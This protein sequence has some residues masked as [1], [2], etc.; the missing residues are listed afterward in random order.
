MSQAERRHFRGEEKV[1]IL[2]LHLLEGKAV[3]DLCEQHKI[4]PSLFYQW[5]RTFFENGMRAFEGSSH[6]LAG[7]FEGHRDGDADSL[8]AVQ[9]PAL[10][11]A[12]VDRDERY[13]DEYEGDGDHPS[14][15]GTTRSW[16]GAFRPSDVGVQDGKPC[17]SL[18]RHGSQQSRA[19]CGARGRLPSGGGRC[20]CGPSLRGG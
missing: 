9:G 4:T 18:P 5:Q 10:R 8:R 12:E 11:L 16:K 6:A 2:R 13:R 3:S 14:P 1:R 15:E 7:D 19:L 20:G 17:C